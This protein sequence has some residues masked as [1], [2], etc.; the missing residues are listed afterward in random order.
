MAAV[1]G[2]PVPF[3]IGNRYFNLTHFGL[4][5]LVRVT[6]LRFNIHHAFVSIWVFDFDV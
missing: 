4:P 6:W 5:P 3:S 1:Y 2:S